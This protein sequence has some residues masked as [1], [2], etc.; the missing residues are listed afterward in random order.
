MKKIHFIGIGGTGL[1]A[2]AIV[3]IES[4]YL[5]SGSDMQESALTQKLRDRGAK[6]FIGHSAANLAD[7]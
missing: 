4:G 3:L 6:V 5:V 7:A 2:I 1:S